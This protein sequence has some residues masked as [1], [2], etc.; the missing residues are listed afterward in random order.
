MRAIAVVADVCQSQGQF[1]SVC[2]AD[3]LLVLAVLGAGVMH[4]Q[5]LAHGFA[6]SPSPDLAVA[7][8]DHEAAGLG[9][10]AGLGPAVVDGDRGPGP[11]A[12]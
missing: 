4:Y 6:P 2:C 1:G 5:R 8:L 7:R 9:L 12:P 3:A 10:G 11:A